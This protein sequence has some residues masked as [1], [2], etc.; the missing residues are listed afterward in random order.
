MKHLK[1]ISDSSRSD[2]SRSDSSRMIDAEQITRAHAGAAQLVPLETR[3]LLEPLFGH[4]FAD[5][6]VFSD[7]AAAQTADALHAKAFTVGQRIGFA[8]GQYQPDSPQGQR[9]LAHELAHTIQQG[10]VDTM[11]KALEV[12]GRGEDNA[13]AVVSSLGSASRPAVSSIAAAVQCEDAA[14]PSVDWS[15]D[16]RNPHFQAAMPI[17]A[18]TGTA[19]VNTT[20]AALQVQ[21]PDL[22]ARAGYDWQKGLSADMKYHLDPATISAQASPNGVAGQFQ[23]PNLQLSGGYMNGAPFANA[24]GEL[25]PFRAE[26]A[27]DPSKGVTGQGS[28]VWPGSSGYI[29]TGGAGVR[30][31]VGPVTGALST[32]WDRIKA[33]A[34]AAT[35]LAGVPLELGVHGG[36]GM[37]GSKPSIGGQVTAPNIAGTPLSPSAGVMYQ[38]GEVVPTLGV[39]TPLPF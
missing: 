12:S 21:T 9:L 6:R 14:A 15:L 18:G 29:G 23:M 20:A 13:N 11:P 24:Q 2:S 28:A 3:S 4:S 27:F 34:T 26:A 30:Q 22:T 38:N 32:D 36:V 33:E 31:Q 5:V 35:S 25:G 16:P 1:M 17:G 19:T 7:S 10:R 37:D 39:G 8:A